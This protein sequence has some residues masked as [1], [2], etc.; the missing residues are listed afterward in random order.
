MD[1]E[2]E[3]YRLIHELNHFFIFALY[4]LTPY[5]ILLQTMEACQSCN[6]TKNV[7][8]GCDSSK[9]LLIVLLGRLNS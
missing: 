6:L 9:T 7:T 3:L 2:A 5:Y 8:M 1:V 4:Y